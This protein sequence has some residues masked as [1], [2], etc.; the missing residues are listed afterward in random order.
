MRID[1]MGCR[2]AEF[3]S[4]VRVSR[5]FEGNDTVG[6]P[7]WYSA[8]LQVNCAACGMA[9]EFYGVVPSDNP[10]APMTD[11]TGERLK[12]PIRPRLKSAAA[13]TIDPLPATRRMLP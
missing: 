8:E 4:I 12:V 13:P 5:N 2:H 7:N 6:K 9:F 1:P 10:T 3:N 11:R